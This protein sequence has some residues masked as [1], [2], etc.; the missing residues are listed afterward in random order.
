MFGDVICGRAPTVEQ[1][2][3]RTVF[4]A[5][6]F[7]GIIFTKAVIQKSSEC[8]NLSKE[9]ID[10]QNAEQFIYRDTLLDPGRHR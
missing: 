2:L 4:C 6:N 7:E 9:N 5:E 1:F 10:L 3:S 8:Q